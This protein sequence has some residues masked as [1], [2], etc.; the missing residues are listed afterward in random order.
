MFLSF[1]RPDQTTGH[2]S[3]FPVVFGRRERLERVGAER[4][5][6]GVPAT[7]RI[8]SRFQLLNDG[9]AAGRGFDLA[10]PAQPVEQDGGFRGIVGELS[11]SVAEGGR[12]NVIEIGVS[13]HF[14]A[15]LS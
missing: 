4:V 13:G 7:V 9:T 6:T 14:D 3:L 5:V 8:E 12:H 2:I 15:P 1:S 11:A 10:L